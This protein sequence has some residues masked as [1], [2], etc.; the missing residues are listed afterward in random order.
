MTEGGD[1]D[2]LRGQELIERLCDA[3]L[4]RLLAEDRASRQ[5]GQESG[6][7]EGALLDVAEDYAEDDLCGRVEVVEGEAQALLA[8]EGV[9]LEGARLQ[10]LLDRLLH[11]RVVALK[12]ALTER[13]EDGGYVQRS[14]QLNRTAAAAPDAASEHT[15]G[16]LAAAYVKRQGETGAWKNVEE[17]T[18]VVERF[19]KW[20]G[21]DT[22]LSSVDV[23]RCEEVFAMFSSRG[24]ASTT[25][26]KELRWLRA[27]FN[28]AVEREWMQR[29]P[30]RS[31]RVKEPAARDQRVPFTDSDLRV[32]FGAAL[33]KA[34]VARPIG[35]A[36]KGAGQGEPVYMPERY[37]GLLLGLYSGLRC[38]EV[39]RLRTA[40]VAEVDGVLCLVVEPEAEGVLKTTSSRRQV[41]VH[42]HLIELGLADFVEEQRAAGQVQLFSRA[43]TLK[44]P[45][46]TL[47]NWFRRYRH[48]QGISEKKKPFHSLRHTFR[49]RLSD[50]D[51]QDSKVSDLMG[52]SDGSMTHG[53]YGSRASVA[54]LRDAIE[55][56]DF[57]EP[58]AELKTPTKP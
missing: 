52:H 22:L 46:A 23:E 21:A 57:R 44:R 3:Y 19:V 1:H 34:V 47:S 53:R 54:R 27:L 25:Q 48:A 5:S 40:D 41:P 24:L 38:G 11:T 6:D 15:V 58:L 35:S 4:R 16:E 33:S 50:A 51:V 2:V 20:L 31:L 29:N 56:L 7:V 39:I 10:Q 55:R 30:A 26:N 9:E 13:A 28:F 36:A 14:F 18:T 17:R 37:W 32:L 8:A 43:M 42:S 45:E 12:A 49:Q